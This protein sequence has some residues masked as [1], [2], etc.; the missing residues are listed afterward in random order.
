MNSLEKDMFEVTKCQPQWQYF[1]QKNIPFNGQIDD[2]YV[3]SLSF[4]VKYA[5]NADEPVKQL[6]EPTQIRVFGIPKN[7]VGNRLYLAEF[8][9]PFIAR[10][11]EDYNKLERSYVEDVL[12][13]IREDMFHERFSLEDILTR[14]D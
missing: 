14:W 12:D 11:L 7:G 3:Q 1:K 4:Y 10:S 13:E 8:S 6:Y 2:E 9:L 5:Q